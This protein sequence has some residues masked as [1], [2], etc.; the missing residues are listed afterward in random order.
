MHKRHLPIANPCHEDWDG[1]HAQ[2]GGRRFCDQCDKSV[3]DLSSMP[4]AQA[5]ALLAAPR[6][7]RICIRYRS[8]SH[9]RVRFADPT[10]PAPM[11]RIFAA[12]RAAVGT[13]AA[14]MALA[15]CADANRAPAEVT[16][17]HCSYE[18]GPFGYTLE[19]GEG[20]CPPLESVT[21]H[22][23]EDPEVM[24]KIAMDPEPGPVVGELEAIDPEPVPEMGEAPA[25]E[26]VVQGQEAVPE[27]P[28]EPQIEH[29]IMGDWAGPEPGVDPTDVPCEKPPAEPSDAPERF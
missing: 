17:T 20:N 14:A 23:V 25:I 22:Q 7:G 16:P 24:G 8:D 6:S 5:K 27:P 18:V 26:E 12:L 11:P 13:A 19:R 3:H 15:G 4:E 29:E 10:A 28:T 21:S 9:G 1:M 2:D